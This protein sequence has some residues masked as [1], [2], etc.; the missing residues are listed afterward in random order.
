[1]GVPLGVPPFCLRSWLALFPHLD[2]YVKQ[3]YH[4]IPVFSQTD[5]LLLS[6]HH[7]KQWFIFEYNYSTFTVYI[8]WYLLHLQSFFV[9]YFINYFYYYY[10]SCSGFSYWS[11]GQATS[12]RTKYNIHGV[13]SWQ[14]WGCCLFRSRKR[15]EC[16]KLK[17]NPVTLSFSHGHEGL[18]YYSAMISLI[19]PLEGGLIFSTTFEGGVNKG[20]GGKI[21]N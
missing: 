1:M 6:F 5:I 11:Y 8:W 14:R 13:W 12:F 16:K 4:S 10:N 19:S 7:V 17:T 3:S 18:V 9:L 21:K 2:W 15:R 20:G